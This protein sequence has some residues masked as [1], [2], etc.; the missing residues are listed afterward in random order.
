M[1]TAPIWMLDHLPAAPLVLQLLASGVGK[2][3]ED[4][5]SPCFPT[6]AWETW[7]KLLASGFGLAHP[8]AL[9]PFGK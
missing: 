3:A 4:G 9:K 6:I 5:L 8:Q 1:L 2:I 7:N